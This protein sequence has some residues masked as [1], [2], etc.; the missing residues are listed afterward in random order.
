[1]CCSDFKEYDNRWAD[2]GIESNDDNLNNE[3]KM[4]EN[5]N[6][7][8]ESCGNIDGNRIVGGRIANLHEF[9]WMALISHK[10]RAS[11]GG[12]IRIYNNKQVRL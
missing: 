10:T 9:P 5:L 2:P 6:L 1:M 4:H 3:I 11:S 7:L 12:H 8:T